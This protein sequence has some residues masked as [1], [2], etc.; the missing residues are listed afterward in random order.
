MQTDKYSFPQRI[1]PL[2]GIGTFSEWP[3]SAN[4]VDPNRPKRGWRDLVSRAEILAYRAATFLL[5]FVDDPAWLAF[6][7]C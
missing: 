2:S 4:G 7:F 3:A 6:M 1:Q 5:S